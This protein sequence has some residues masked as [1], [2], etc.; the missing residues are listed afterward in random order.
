VKVKIQLWE[1]GAKTVI[2]YE[3]VGRRPVRKLKLSTINVASRSPCV[4][5]PSPAQKTSQQDFG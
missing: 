3:K 4:K 5:L 2:L 1:K